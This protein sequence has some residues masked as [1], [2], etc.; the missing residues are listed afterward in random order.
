MK[1]GLHLLHS[2]KGKYIYEEAKIFLVEEKI[3]VKL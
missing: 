2:G 3:F 1:V